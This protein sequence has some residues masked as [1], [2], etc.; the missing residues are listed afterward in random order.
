MSQTF[1]NLKVN[2][3]LVYGDVSL[4]LHTATKWYVDKEIKDL[5]SDSPS[6]LDTLKEIVEFIGDTEVSLTLVKRLN[7]AKSSRDDI[8]QQLYTNIQT[9]NTK[10]DS[11]STKLV[12]D[13]SIAE[14]DI[15]LFSQ[16]LVSQIDTLTT[17]IQSVSTDLVSQKE[18]INKRIVDLSTDI[19]LELKSKS[20]ELSQKIV[21][22]LNRKLDTSDKYRKRPDGN[23]QILKKDAFLYIG[24]HWRIKS[25]QRGVRDS[26]I[27]EY[28][29]K[30]LNDDHFD[31]HWTVGIPFIK[32]LYEPSCFEQWV[33][34]SQG[35]STSGLLQLSTLSTSTENNVVWYPNYGEFSTM[36]GN[37]LKT[38]FNNL[39][40]GCFSTVINIGKNSRF[41]KND[42]LYVVGNL[43]QDK[44]GS[45]YLNE[46]MKLVHSVVGIGDI[47]L[48]DVPLISRN[49]WYFVAGSWKHGEMNM[50]ITNGTDYEHHDTLSL[51][52]GSRIE[53]SDSNY[54]IGNPSLSDSSVS[55]KIRMSELVIHNSFKDIHDY[56]ELFQRSKVRMGRL[57]L[58]FSPTYT[59]VNNTPKLNEDDLYTTTLANKSLNSFAA[60]TVNG[61]V[62]TWGNNTYGGIQNVYNGLGDILKDVSQE[63]ESGVTKLSSTFRAFSALKS[64][65]TVV[66]WGQ[67]GHG[68]S[69]PSEV[70]E[71]DNIKVVDIFSNGF[72][73]AALREDNSVIVW[74]HN[75]QGGYVSGN[76]QNVK[77]IYSTER[78]FAA[79][80]HDGSVSTWGQY[81]YGGDSK[82]YNSDKTSIGD[83]TD[84]LSGSVSEIYTSQ[85]AFTALKTDGTIVSWGFEDWGGNVP[86]TIS[87]GVTSVYSTDRSFS[88][89]TND[90][91]VISW[92]HP[93]YGGVVPENLD[94]VCKIFSTHYAYAT[95]K[96]DGT[97]VT[98]GNQ[99]L[100]GYKGVY[101]YDSG[102]KQ[103]IRITDVS[104]QLTQVVDINSTYTA[105]AALKYDG[106]VVTWGYN[107]YGG[108]R[109][110]L[111][112]VNDIYSTSR[113]FAALKTDGTV[114]TWGSSGYGGGTQTFENIDHVT[115]SNMG[116]TLHQ[117]V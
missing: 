61:S 30:D 115:S 2:Q 51:T 39:E 114:E 33:F 28:N 5:I 9:V 63:L 103:Y 18:R 21:E 99:A 8:S 15:S 32:I 85:A 93:D 42:K 1:S 64:D 110:G 100:G 96:N 47:I 82:I 72:A 35:E 36:F 16:E 73:F 11:V 79:L 22:G 69:T 49:S 29:S 90:G 78:A 105:F 108:N 81:N 55:G 102:S 27:F 14:N 65:G 45:I 101:R 6:T 98:W 57:G 53:N 67:I 59:P 116:F 97:V 19:S 87:V 66:S 58:K 94:N 26:L 92:G 20:Q 54:G 37:S 56:G 60:I 46:D 107:K 50:Y 88:A 95:L 62:V 7:D 111:Q 52:S 80:K 44:G 24:D 43:G 89:L 104:D 13:I 68:G 23:F 25:N 91:T 83:V 75:E 77:H 34:D 117:S 12:T 4:P 109:E 17:N 38:S 70:N 41:N 40:E 106:S 3:T 112:N 48:D 74:G 113:A 76:I 86:E 10:V 31:D 84:K 71:Q